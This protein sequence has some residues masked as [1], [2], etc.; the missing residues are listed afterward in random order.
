MTPS[1][2]PSYRLISTLLVFVVIFISK[3]SRRRS[4]P[5]LYSAAIMTD[6]PLDAI[7]RLSIF[8]FRR[9]HD[10]KFQFISSRAR[11]WHSVA[12]TAPGV[13]PMHAIA[14]ASDLMHKVAASAFILRAFYLILVIALIYL[15]TMLPIILIDLWLKSVWS[16]LAS[17]GL[18]LSRFFFFFSYL[19]PLASSSSMPQPTSIVITVGSSIIRSNSR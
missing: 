4:S 13:Y 8:H 18:P 15:V 2:T 10:F 6:F 17:F 1:I 9:R 16:W 3:L 19:S 5:S 12:V 14:N 11:S 7:L